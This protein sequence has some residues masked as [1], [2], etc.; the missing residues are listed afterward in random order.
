[1]FLLVR[2]HQQLQQQ[3]KIAETRHAANDSDFALR[4]AG[5]AAQTGK[6]VAI[7]PI[8]RSSS[9]RQA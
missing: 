2:T 1:L 7:R 6:V 4:G 3:C 9:A 5:A 8:Q